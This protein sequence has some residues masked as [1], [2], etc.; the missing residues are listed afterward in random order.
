MLASI[1][2]RPRPGTAAQGESDNST[3]PQYQDNYR[4]LI[5]SGVWFGP[6]DGGIFQ[7]LPVFL[8]RL[9]ATPALV[10]LLT[11]GQSIL[12]IFSYIPGG[13]YAERR[14]DLVRLFV[15]GAVIARLAYLLLALIPFFVDAAYLPIV[16]VILWTLIAIPNAVTIPAWTAVMQQAIPPGRA[17]G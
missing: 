14:R 11:S 16:A 8:A 12:G 6:V 13:A 10:S 2:R 1:W 7:Y 9:G 3:A 17:P 4:N 5:L 15:R